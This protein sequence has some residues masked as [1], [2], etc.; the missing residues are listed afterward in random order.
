MGSQDAL[1]DLPAGEARKEAGQRQ[2]E[3]ADPAWSWRSD[4]LDAIWE[5]AASGRTFT[6]D[7]VVA[8]V[9]LPDF[10]P[11][12]NNAVGA[13]FS[14]AAKRGWIVSTGVYRKS[15]RPEAHARVIAVW[16]GNPDQDL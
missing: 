4:A 8:V 6:A 11:N 7:D 13:V 10:G 16:A 5:L 2:A 3:Y 1:F 12:R 14:S 9:G 15:R